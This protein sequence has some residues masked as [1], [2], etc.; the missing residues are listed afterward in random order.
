MSLK[1]GEMIDGRYEVLAELGEGSMAEVYKVRH[2]QLGTEHALKVLKLEHESIR[3]RMMREG[4]FQAKLRH[5]NIVPVTDVVPMGD[6]AGLVMELVDGGSLGDLL[7]AHRLNEQQVDALAL[8]LLDGVEAAHKAGLIHRDLKPA[9]ILLARE[10]KNLIPKITDFGLA[11]ALDASQTLTKSGVMMGTPA[12]MAPEQ[13]HDAK[14]VD[15]R[16]DVFSVGAILY[17][18]VAGRRPFDDPNIA[19]VLTAVLDG[20]YPPVTKFAPT[21]PAHRVKAIDAAL[22]VEAEDRVGS[23]AELRR[24]WIGEEE[25]IP[26]RDAETTEGPFGRAL[27]D[28]LSAPKDEDRNISHLATVIRKPTPA[29]AP[30]RP[31]APPPP[32]KKAPRR[33]G[34]PPSSDSSMT[35]VFIALVLLLVMAIAAFLGFGLGTTILIWLKI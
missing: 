19:N 25:D 14:R 7:A 30:P 6:A 3:E 16:A 13:I 4:Q 31:A 22:K 2:R 11:K 29:P 15:Q 21:L 28:S 10:G 5:P 26:T 1:K 18:M 8:G 23:C 32:P 34:P 33:R 17:H 9:N 12:Y 27:L 35:Y 24:M 20:D